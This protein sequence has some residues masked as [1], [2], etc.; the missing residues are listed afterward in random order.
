MDPDKK[1]KYKFGK[2][3]KEGQKGSLIS[4]FGRY[5]PRFIEDESI[6]GNV[7]VL[8]LLSLDKVD[9][10][11][12]DFWPWDKNITRWRLIALDFLSERHRDLNDKASNPFEQNHDDSHLCKNTNAFQT[13]DL[14]F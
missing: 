4:N 9:D 6:E 14:R 10:K 11:L 8:T 7:E 5:P 1:I 13:S 2:N 12:W 3:C